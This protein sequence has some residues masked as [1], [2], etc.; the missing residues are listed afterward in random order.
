MRRAC[1]AKRSAIRKKQVIPKARQRP[2]RE[3]PRRLRPDDRRA[4]SRRRGASRELGGG[5]KDR[6]GSVRLAVR[7]GMVRPP[8]A[9]PVRADVR[10]LFPAAQHDHSAGHRL[11]SHVGGDDG[12]HRRRHGHAR[13]P[14]PQQP[15]RYGADAEADLLCRR[16]R[17]RHP[18][19]SD[20]H[21]KAGREKA[22][23]E[24]S[25]D[26]TA[27]GGTALGRRRAARR[28]V[29]PPRPVRRAAPGRD[30]RPFVGLRV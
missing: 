24:K 8:E 18:Q 13:T 28:G 9:G 2:G 14:R 23:P 22:D 15:A 19:G 26:K 25:I 7:R 27:G 3:V 16:G 11:A 30:L 12:Q 6:R 5:G 20:A 1:Y 21:S 17:R 29:R 4:R 10:A